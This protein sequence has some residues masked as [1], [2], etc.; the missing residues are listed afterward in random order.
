VLD[1]LPE[2]LILIAIFLGIGFPVHEFAHAFAADRLG[3][4]TARYMGRLTLN[5][6]K[7]FDPL[8]GTLFVLS[9]AVGGFI[10]GWAKPT[11][12]NTLNLRDRRNSEV[13][14]ALAGPG[15]NLILACVGAL[16]LRA[17]VAV[18]AIEP[19]EAV[20]FVL[21]LLYSFVYY[22]VALMVFNLIPI[23]PLDGSTILFRFLPP[24]TA[25]RLRPMLAQYGFV[26]VLF[27]VFVFGSQIARVMRD[28][29]A[30]LVGG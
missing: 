6:A 19:S 10:I 8:G 3:D 27:G 18:D 12:V 5:P 11:P 17:I 23:P 28:V 14:V 7:H 22:N 20:F 9:V 15:V 24:A 4:S 2:K 30:F 26:I 13:V 16:V 29:A 21:G 25:W 1:N